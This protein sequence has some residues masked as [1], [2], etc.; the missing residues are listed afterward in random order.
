MLSEAPSGPPRFL[1][2]ENP[3]MRRLLALLTPLALVAGTG[4]VVTPYSGHMRTYRTVE[5]TQYRFSGPHP[6]PGG[7]GW[8]LEEYDHVHDYAPEVQYYSYT[9]DVYQYR[10][11]TVVWYLDYH[12]IPTGG[13]CNLHGRHNHDYY[14]RQYDGWSYNWDR[15]R[16]V[17]VYNNPRYTHGASPVGGGYSQPAPSYPAP[18][19]GYYPPSNNSG[20]SLVTERIRRW[21]PSLTTIQSSISPKVYWRFMLPPRNRGSRDSPAGAG[22]FRMPAT[23]TNVGNKSSS[24]TGCDVRL[25]PGMPPGGRIIR[26]GWVI[27]RNSVLL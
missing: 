9:N 12:P 10:G 1:A 16:E 7:G 22:S 2:R 3:H 17:Y 23:S 25:P 19:N 21:R 5:V 11:P 8:C 26:Q 15:G 6:I 18:S 24:S 13:Y 14:P 4:C 27:C 20:G